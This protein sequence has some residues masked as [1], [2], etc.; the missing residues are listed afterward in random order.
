MNKNTTKTL[1]Q[2]SEISYD[3]FNKHAVL[4][5]KLDG[6]SDFIDVLQKKF[7]TLEH[8]KLMQH[9]H[10]KKLEETAKEVTYST[11][12]PSHKHLIKR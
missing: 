2:I 12:I 4:T 8:E 3:S 10:L 6:K 1:Q 5:A 9:E 11:K 7:A